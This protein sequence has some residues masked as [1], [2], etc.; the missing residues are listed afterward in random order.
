M[1]TINS[2]DR[3]LEINLALGSNGEL[4]KT[5]NTWISSVPKESLDKIQLSCPKQEKN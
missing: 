3:R 1:S 4:L 5:S 2:L